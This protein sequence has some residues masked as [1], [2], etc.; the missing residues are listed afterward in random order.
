[1][2]GDASLSI[3]ANSLRSDRILMRSDVTYVALQPRYSSTTLPCLD[4]QPKLFIVDEI[5]SMTSLLDV[6]TPSETFAFKAW[7]T[8]TFSD[9]RINPAE[10]KMV[11]RP[12]IWL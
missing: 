8:G 1:M 4:G 2:V 11:T 7:H 3:W 12:R 10:Q 6:L 9:R 5:P